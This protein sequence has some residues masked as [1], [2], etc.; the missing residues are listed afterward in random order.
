M[1]TEKHSGLFALFYLSLIQATASSL[2]MALLFDISSE[3]LDNPIIIQQ[4]TFNGKSPLFT[5]F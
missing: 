3:K 2:S 1:T 4:D 5:W